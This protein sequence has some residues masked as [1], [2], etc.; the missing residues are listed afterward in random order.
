ML[1]IRRRCLPNSQKLRACDIAVEMLLAREQQAFGYSISER[2]GRV[3]FVLV[4]FGRRGTFARS[5]RRAPGCGG[6]AGRAR[7]CRSALTL[8]YH[9]YNNRRYTTL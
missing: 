2:S 6:R 9:M 3:G 4:M 5:P 1:T 7:F 8:H